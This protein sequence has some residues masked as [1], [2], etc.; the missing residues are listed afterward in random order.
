ML[1]FQQYHPLIAGSIETPEGSQPALWPIL[2][3]TVT[4][5]YRRIFHRY[6]S[7]DQ[8]EI[9]ISRVF[10]SLS[11]SYFYD[12]ALEP[13]L[14]QTTRYILLTEMRDIATDTAFS[15]DAIP[16]H[17]TPAESRDITSE[18]ILHEQIREA[19][20]KVNNQRY[21]V[22]L[23]L[24]Y[25]YQLDNPDLA[26]FFGISVSQATTWISRARKALRQANQMDDSED[27]IESSVDGS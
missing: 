6:P 2:E 1:G 27:D 21:R 14:W 26:S 18:Y 3:R 8:R 10:L 19:I 15:L 5:N 22:I 20:R 13:W 7:P 25:I 24:L 4:A 23:L 9:I 17:H 12:T 11:E 16:P